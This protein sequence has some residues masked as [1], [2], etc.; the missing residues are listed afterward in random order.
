LLV[1]A[2]LMGNCSNMLAVDIQCLHLHAPVQ[3]HTRVCMCRLRLVSSCA[4]ACA[5]PWFRLHA[6]CA[7]FKHPVFGVEIHQEVDINCCPV[8]HL[9]CGCAYVLDNT[10]PARCT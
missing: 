10:T 8:W 3:V 5:C 9:L 7:P 2:Q 4:A 6:C 1:E